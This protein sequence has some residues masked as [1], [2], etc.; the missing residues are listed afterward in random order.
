MLVFAWLGER[1][2]VCDIEGR[3]WTV[4]SGRVEPGETPLAA[5]ER[6]LAEEGAA[7]L[8]SWTRIGCYRIGTGRAARW[9]ECFAGRVTEMGQPAPGGESRAGRLVALDDL[10]SMYSLWNPLTEQVFRHSRASLPDR[11]A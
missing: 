4:P 5:A 1:V 8:E 2:L 11:L 3:G 9:A 10:P 6:E 7:R